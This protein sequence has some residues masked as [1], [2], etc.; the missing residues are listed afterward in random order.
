MHEVDLT[1]LLRS[2]ETLHEQEKYVALAEPIRKL[3]RLVDRHRDLTRH[4]RVWL[5][6][7]TARGGGVAEI[8]PRVM[9]LMHDAANM[10]ARWLIMGVHG[11]CFD[12]D[13]QAKARF[14]SI[15][16][17]IHNAIH[18]DGVPLDEWTPEWL[19]TDPAAVEAMWAQVAACGGA[20]AGS[21][22]AGEAEEAGAHHRVREPSV[23]DA[24]DPAGLPLQ[25]AGG[26]SPGGISVAD[27]TPGAAAAADGPAAG[28]HP[29]TAAPPAPTAAAQDSAAAV[30]GP[31][32][33]DM[34]RAIY[35]RVN[36]DN[37]RTFLHSFL[38]AADP[39]RDLVVIHDPQPAGMITELKRRVPGLRCVLRMHVGLDFAND[40]TRSAWAFLAP[41]MT[42]F[43][44]VVWSAP[45]YIQDFVRSRSSVVH[46]GI[47]V[48]TPKNK[49]LSP[50]EVT[51][52]TVT[53]T[54][55][56]QL[57]R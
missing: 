25:V 2:Y 55:T 6:S 54:V 51:Q 21:S 48:L 35:E 10:N 33:L 18:G 3:R 42:Q 20:G 53:V 4:V 7:S 46:P 32:Y 28:A 5:I 11:D 43:D 56:V 9:C 36:R 19:P 39:A 41:Y 57:A 27:T 45:E 52:V 16:K 49:E 1:E 31:G 14:F 38:Q 26:E 22:E 12:D 50:Y 23:M 44:E 34:I 8:M 13:G 47:S 40:A 24:L 29:V 30:R 37:A 15:T 17:H